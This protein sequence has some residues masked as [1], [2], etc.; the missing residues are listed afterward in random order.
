MAGRTY[1]CWPASIYGLVEVQNKAQKMFKV[2][3][4]MNVNLAGLES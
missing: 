2:D 4:V 1:S 3:E